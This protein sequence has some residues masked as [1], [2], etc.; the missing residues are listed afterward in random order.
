MTSLAAEQW[1]GHTAL[2]YYTSSEGLPGGRVGYASDTDT[3]ALAPW[4]VVALPFPPSDM[5]MA[6]GK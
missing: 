3:L 2:H 6:D 4:L 1:R 5:L